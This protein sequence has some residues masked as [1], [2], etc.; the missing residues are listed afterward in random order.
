M[1]GGTLKSDGLSQMYASGEVTIFNSEC[2]AYIYICQFHHGR[3]IEL[4]AMSCSFVLI[5]GL[6]LKG[7]KGNGYARLNEH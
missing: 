4:A 1:S 2:Q 5:N 6:Q 3:R 7:P